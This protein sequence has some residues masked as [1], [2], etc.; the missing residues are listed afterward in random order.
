MKLKNLRK[1]EHE[2]VYLAD[3]DED[4]ETRSG[5]EEVIDV[6]DSDEDDET[7]VINPFYQPDPEEMDLN[8][9]QLI[10]VLVHNYLKEALPELAEVFEH[11]FPSTSLHT[12]LQLSE[13]IKHFRK[14][15]VKAKGYKLKA[16]S[17]ELTTKDNK[18]GGRK[19]RPTGTNIRKFSHAEDEVIREAIQYAAGG[20]IDC[21][22]I[23]KRLNRGQRSIQNRVESL[24]L[25]NG[26][27]SYKNYSQ[28]EDFTILET[29]ILPRLKQGERLSKIVLSNCYYEQLAKDLN[30]KVHSVRNR[31]QG[32]LQPCLLKYYAGTLNLW[33]QPGR[34]LQDTLSVA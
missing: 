29:L 4:V 23:A 10:R 8:E 3:E 22:A 21:C 28:N 32:S 2:V 16:A 31:W 27:H 30:R 5:E 1:K 15:G 6:S 34:I 33:W 26:I 24:K 13:V 7:I 17:A 14:A 18:A 9:D 20:K 11:S 25:N 19:N 12:H